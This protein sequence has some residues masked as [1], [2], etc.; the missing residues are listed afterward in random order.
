MR[1]VL[2]SLSILVLAVTA[3][4]TF[5]SGVKRDKRTPEVVYSSDGSEVRIYSTEVKDTL[6]L[7]VISDTHLWLSDEREEPFRKYSAR[8]ASAYNETRHFK[9]GEKTNPQRELLRTLQLAR[10]RGADAVALLGD[11]LSYPSERAVE[12]LKHALDTTAIPYYYTCGNHDWHYEGMEGSSHDLRSKWRAERL[13]P[14][15]N[16]QDPDAYTVEIKG[17][18]LFFVDE[19]TYEVQPEQLAAVEAEVRSGKP[20]IL[21]HHIPFYAPGRPVGYG[22]G[23]PDW[24]AKADGGYQLERRERWSESGHQQVDYQFYD[25]VTTASNLLASFAGHVHLYGVDIING[26]PHYTVEAN[27]RGGYYFVTIMPLKR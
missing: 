17:V 11:M 13:S 4:V 15:F 1:R 22:I 7:M 12:W 26:R 6:R 9:T 20:F 21:F 27:F 14:L 3:L 23:H 25:K 5:T 24:G 8:M 19:S 10:R 18:K 2:L 16:G